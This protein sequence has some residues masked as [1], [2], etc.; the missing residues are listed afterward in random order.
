[1]GKA[2]GACPLGPG[3]A[4]IED[5][6]NPW[7]G[8]CGSGNGE[9]TFTSGFELPFTSQPTVW[10][11]EYFKN[12]LHYEW[13]VMM[14]PGGH[15]QWEPVVAGDEEPPIAISADG[16]HNQT[17]G[18]LTSDVAL[19]H[20]EQY[21]E[22]VAHFA[23]DWQD[24]SAQFAAAWYKL[25]TR[26]MG[27]RTRC[28]NQD[29]AP[30]PQHWQNPLPQRDSPVPDFEGVKQRIEIV[31]ELNDAY[32]LFARLAWQCAST[33][34]VTDYQGG[35]NGARLRLAPASGWEVNV[36]LELTLSLL[37]PLLEEF[38]PALSWADLIVLAGT[39]A[40]EKAS[41]TAMPFC[42]V[43]R[44]DDQSGEAWRFLEPRV[45]SVS[46]LSH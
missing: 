42:S 1:M 19:V 17:I 4:P 3:P 18:L 27:P 13:S 36:N 10:D 25:T 5:P 6:L 11:N 43:G 35:C 21:R 30:P 16:S 15:F 29:T 34:R 20:D 2:H 40:L 37:Q 7:P 23:E 26:D 9:D 31:L 14:G 38:S 24:F 44:V 45:R 28:S 12:L 41:N 22:I 46:Q 8:L 33:F 32:G 39:T